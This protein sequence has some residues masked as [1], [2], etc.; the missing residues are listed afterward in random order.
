V[1]NFEHCDHETTGVFQNQQ[2]LADIDFSSKSPPQKIQTI[3]A[4][5]TTT[6]MVSVIQQ[7]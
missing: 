2:L 6:A 1:A 4:I 5:F 7:K 3:K